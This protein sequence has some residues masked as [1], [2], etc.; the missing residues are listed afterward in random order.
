[1]CD[2]EFQVRRCGAKFMNTISMEMR[3]TVGCDGRILSESFVELEIRFDCFG[4]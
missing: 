2:E 4:A 3:S 1:M